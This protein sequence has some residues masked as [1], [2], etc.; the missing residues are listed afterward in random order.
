MRRFNATRP[1]FLLPSIHVLHHCGVFMT[2]FTAVEFRALYCTR[3]STRRSAFTSLR[4]GLKID[5]R[6]LKLATHADGMW[7]NDTVWGQ[8][9]APPGHVPSYRSRVGREEKRTDRWRRTR[10]AVKTD[11]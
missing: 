1:I 8:C 7:I 2:N 4:V 11:R 9:A 10:S 5:L 6:Y 3:R